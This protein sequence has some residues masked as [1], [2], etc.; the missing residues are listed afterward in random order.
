MLFLA[1]SVLADNPNPPQNA[2]QL[3]K[4]LIQ[5]ITAAQMRALL[6]TGTNA[7]D[8][9]LTN[10]IPDGAL[11]QLSF[12][13][14]SGGYV[15]RSI[16]FTNLFRGSNILTLGDRTKFFSATGNNGRAYL[17]FWQ[18]H[19][20]GN[21]LAILGGGDVDIIPGDGGGLQL[22]DSGGATSAQLYFQYRNAPNGA[23]PLGQSHKIEF[24]AK[25]FIGGSPGYSTT[26][27]RPGI[28]G[29]A[30]VTNASVQY[31]E[32]RFYAQVPDWNSGNA[33]MT[34]DVA[35]VE[36]FRAS[37][38][39]VVA[40]SGK[41][42]IGDGSG[43]TN[44]VGT[45]TNQAININY[46]VTPLTTIYERDEFFGGPTTP[47]SGQIGALGWEYSATTIGTH[48]DT[49]PPNIGN[50]KV[51]TSTVLSND[52]YLMLGDSTAA[53]GFAGSLH[54]NAGWTNTYIFKLSSTSNIRAIIGLVTDRP[55]SDVRSPSGYYM[56][57]DT[58]LSA[59]FYF[60]T[61]TAYGGAESSFVDSGTA[62]DTSYHKLTM[63]SETA[64]AVKFQI[65]AGTVQTI[66][67]QLTSSPVMPIFWVRTYDTTAK[68][69]T[70]DFF[71]FKMSVT[72]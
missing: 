18:D 65:D 39:G 43:L 8:S 23:N 67:T 70:A 46:A 1:C 69:V 36:V 64:S 28:Q 32:L 68:S 33:T 51:T 66:T 25:K 60:C 61:K 48:I 34:P 12:P 55:D 45:I 13:V 44:L 7:V 19:G 37:T 38:N 6:G 2:S 71:E 9:P 16:A 49:T 5:K 57:L 20:T 47:T 72:R 41:K 21:G 50:V 15:N 59:N 17:D 26:D 63:W 53:Q 24:R 31:G 22:G 56:K 11:I 58:G 54:N 35:G 40:A 30:T 29:W 3:G 52:C 10:Y 27:A 14:A 62:G 42:F 4:L